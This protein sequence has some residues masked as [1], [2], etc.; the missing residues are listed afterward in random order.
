MNLRTKLAATLSIAALALLTGCKGDTGPTGPQGPAGPAG[1]GGDGGTSGIVFQIPSNADTPTDAANAAWAALQPQIT[2]QSVTIASPPKVTFKVTTSSG[3]PIVGLGNTSLASGAKYPGYTNLAF[4]IA[5]LVPASNGS[6]SHWV[7][8]IVTTVPTLTSDGGTTSPGPTRPST[9]NTGT[10]TDN[11][12]GTYVYTFFRDI[13]QTKAQVD[14]MTFT[15]ANVKDD[16]GDLTYEPS[17]V[18]RLTIQLSGNAPGTGSNTPTGVTN[19]TGVPLAHAVDAIYDFTP[20]TGQ[21]VTTSGR[22]MVATENCD[23]CHQVLG[24]IPGG[25][26]EANGAG[27]HG[28]SRNDVRYC[29]VCHTEQRKFGR[30][31]AAYDATTLTFKS[32][33][34]GT[35]LAS[36]STYRFRDRS[37]GNL[38]NFVHH[39]HGGTVLAFK[40]YNFAGVTFNDVLYPQDL[41]NCKKCH[42]PT[43]PATPQANNFNTTP[44]RLACGGC[45]DGIDFSTGKGVTMSDALKGLTS[46]DVSGGLA[47]VAGPLPDDSLCASC[48]GPGGPFDADLVHRPVTPP[49][50]GNALEVSGGNA[51]TNAAWIASNPARLPAGAI[52]VS[53]DIKSVSLDASR[54]PM[55]VFRMLQN[56]TPTPFNN[57][58]TANVNPASGQK[59]IWDNF[60]GSPSLYFAFSVPQDGYTTPSDFNASA[61]GY[62]RT[63]WNGSSTGSGAGTLTGP[64]GNGYYTGT[65]TGVTIPASAVML[66]GGLGYS[67]N[68]TSTL[69]LTQTNLAAYPVT[70]P[71]ATAPQ[72]VVDCSPGGSKATTNACRQGGL[73]VIAP[74]AQKVASGFT[75]RRAIVEDARCNKCHQELGTFTQDAFHAGQRNDGTTCAWCHTPNKTSS[76]WSADSVYFVHAIHAGNKRTTEFTWHA[77]T[78]TSSFAEVAYPGVLNFC[79]GCHIPGA[80]NFSNSDSQ[81]QLANRLYRTVATGAF[82][83]NVGDTFTNFSGAGCATQTQSAPATDVTVH[84]L[85]PYFQATANGTSTPNYGVVFAYNLGPNP[86]NGCTPDGAAYTLA[87]GQSVENV[88]ASESSYAKNLVNSPVAGVCFACHDSNADLAHFEL[89][90]GS[91]YK[92]R[93]TMNTP[94]TAL[95]TVETCIIC[96]GQGK[97]ADIEMVHQQ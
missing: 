49:G 88:A 5:K 27:F 16:L 44:N 59:E 13:T 39:I 95:S 81:A 77:E 87:A 47:H 10:L 8:Y 78:A 66:T 36:T 40:N 69:P 6:P 2:V 1:P 60:M 74:D 3:S 85:A 34:G 46:S 75:G 28:G 76:G 11:K 15:G 52:A 38:P 58:A 55:M 96:H 42:D 41:R 35:D 67:Y 72:A 62:L 79:E 18:H 97:I 53:Y 37:L 32:P 70:V 23:T 7:S 4:A 65:L 51:N 64:D 21:A 61:S 57:F 22:D 56:G 24:G 48:H 68:N 54:H 25:S 50:E 45:H 89:N 90:G 26:A 12:D 31:E 73:I 29:V 83:G 30:T 20:S 93:G 14:G 71:T 9:D 19:V 80:V 33:D 17:L 94:S 43:N 92:P 63:I 91:I 86:S 84:S 82:S